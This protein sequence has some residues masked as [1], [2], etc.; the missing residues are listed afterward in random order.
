VRYR[1]APCETGPI[2]RKIALG[3][4]IV[5]RLHKTYGSSFISRT[6]SRILEVWDL[7]IEVENHLKKLPSLLKEPSRLDLM[8][9][10]KRLNGEGAAFVEASRGMLMHRIKVIEGKIADYRIVTPSMWNLEPR[11]RRF[12]GVAEKIYNGIEKL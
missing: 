7:L 11:C 9:K 5:N 6:L 8:E 4:K 2:A 10:V 1:E 3:D 12:L